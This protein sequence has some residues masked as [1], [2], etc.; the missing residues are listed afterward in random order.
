MAD[1]SISELVSVDTLDSNTLLVCEQ[2]GTAK[3]FSGGQLTSWLLQYVGGKGGILDIQKTSEEGLVST[4]TITYVDTLSDPTTFNVTDG[5]GIRTLAWEESGTSGDGRTHTG[6][7]TYND[8]TQSQIIIR[9]GLKGD[10]GAQTYVHIRYSEDYPNSWSD[11]SDEP[12]NYIGIYTGTSA[13]PPTTIASYD[14]FRYKGNTGNP[15][16]DA[17]IAAKSVQYAVDDQGVDPPSSGWSGDIPQTSSGQWLWTKVSF[18]FSTEAQPIEFFTCARNGSNGL[19]SVSTVNNIDPVD[20]NVT[21]GADDINYE[22]AVS[23]EDKL[24]ALT[25]ADQN[26]QAAITGNTALRINTTLSSSSWS[27]GQQV[28]QNALFEVGNGYVYIVQPAYSSRTEYQRCGITAGDVTSNGSMT[29]NC[30][31]TPTSSVSVNII[32][33]VMT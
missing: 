5:R 28:A 33:M 31:A 30:L 17:T 19:G 25:A 32:R 13:E 8:D 1:K 9:D 20:G 4:Y 22:G 11:T 27:G 7:F 21:I 3:Q 10:T 16:Q 29:F 2:T 26:L 15:G 14:W 18:R 12:N 6:T 24:D 23:V